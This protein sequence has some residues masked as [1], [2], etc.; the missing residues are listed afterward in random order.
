M[1]PIFDLALPGPYHPSAKSQNFRVR[2]IKKYWEKGPA[3]GNVTKPK[4]K[5]QELNF[6]EVFT[7]PQVWAWINSQTSELY[8]PLV[9]FAR[10]VLLGQAGICFLFAANSGPR[11]RPW[12]EQRRDRNVLRW[13][14]LQR[15]VVRRVAWCEST[16]FQEEMNTNYSHSGFIFKVRWHRGLCVW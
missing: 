5:P 13:L 12:A 4:P 14:S 9:S 16:R 15:D 10:K 3:S 11:T 1:L 6:M 2:V 8:L 7:D